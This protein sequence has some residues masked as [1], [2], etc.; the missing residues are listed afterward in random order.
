MIPKRKKRAKMGLREPSQ[1]RCQGHIQ[2]IRGFPCSIELHGDHVCTG[3]IEA[4]HMREGSNGGVG[5]KCDDSTCV[6]LCSHAHQNF[7]SMGVDTF[8]TR[9]HIDLVKTSKVFWEWSP[10]GKIYRREREVK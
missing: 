2:W 8:Q 1:I 3:R 4:H 6:P 10:H 9:Y 7:H 5:L